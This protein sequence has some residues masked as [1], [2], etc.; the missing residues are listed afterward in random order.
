[1]S[2]YATMAQYYDELTDDVPYEEFCAFIEKTFKRYGASPKLIL[3]LACGTGSV[4]KL[5][6]EKGYDMIGA[7][8][9]AEMLT[10]AQQKCIDLWN[11]PTFIRQSMT[12]LNLYGTV[13]AVVCLLDSVNYLDTLTKLDRA[14]ARVSLFLNPGGLFIFDLNTAYKLSSI[15]G[16]SFVREADGVFCVWQAAW[17]ASARTAEFYL[18]F[19]AGSD[20]EHYVRSS[21]VHRERAHSPEEIAAALEKNGMELVKVYG[22]LKFRAPREDEERIFCV[23]RKRT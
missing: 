15:G 2:M 21:E 16:N 20:N 17:K 5:L 8:I 11:K 18:D 12:N 9:S 23:A 19:F 6:A 22:E 13:D 4:T 14:F 7:D 10:E 1:M 3:D